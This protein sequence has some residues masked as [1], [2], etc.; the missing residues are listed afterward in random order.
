MTHR[1]E[2]PTEKQ[3]QFR[4]EAL[5]HSLYNAPVARPRPAFTLV[6]LLTVIGIIAVL[7]AI[8]LPALG[9][10]RTQAR[11]LNCATILHAWGQAFNTYA[12]SY[13][14]KFPHSADRAS[15]SYFFRNADDPLLPQHSS[16]YT[17]LIPPLMSRRAWSSYPLSQRPKGDIWQCP[18]AELTT[19][20]V[21]GYGPSTLG[22]HTYVMN[23]FL[24]F[25]QTPPPGYK[26]LPSFLAAGNAH[27]ASVTL[28]M[29][30]ST[31]MPPAV[32][33]QTGTGGTQCNAGKYSNDGPNN[34][35]DRHPHTR[36]KLGGNL[37]M[38]DGHVEWS[39]GVWDATLPDPEMPPITD[40]RWW[41]Y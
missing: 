3:N 8:L 20:A 30:E 21:Y 33:G 18:Q 37:L 7:I 35:G 2:L 15:N 25:D 9:K 26:K 27:Q 16:A 14:G 11:E 31:L 32:C 1:A 17:D 12:A 34:F 39:D 22:Y 40:R 24:D 28:L 38:I 6:E 41:P 4:I 19:E 5:C 23:R 36:G 13:H 29:F 10:A